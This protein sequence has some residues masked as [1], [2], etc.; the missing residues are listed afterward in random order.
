M[1]RLVNDIVT[2]LYL[3]SDWR[4]ISS[5]VR[6][7]GGMDITRGR[8]S[9]DGDSPPQT[10]TFT[11][12]NTSGD[13]TERDPMGTWYG[14]LGRN[15]PLEVSLR[16]A[17]DTC[18]S[19]VVDGW[20]TMD[21]DAA[22]AWTSYTWITADG[23][24]SDY[25]KSSGK[26]THTIS[27]ANTGKNCYLDGFSHRDLDVTT[28][29]TTNASSNIAGG[30][31]AVD[32][33][34]RMQGYFSDY[35]YVRM[36][37][38]TDESIGVDIGVPSVGS[39]VSGGSIAVPGLTWTSGLV[40][41]FRA[42]I[43][44]Q[45]IRVKIWN[46]ASAEP[47]DWSLTLIDEALLADTD[48]LRVSAG[49]FAIRSLTGAGNTN[50]PVVVSFDDI[51]IRVPMYFGEVSEWPQTRDVSGTDKTVEIEASGVLRR[52][53]QGRNPI[54]APRRAIPND[55]ECTYY[56]PLEEGPLA[57]VAK[58]LVG[59]ANLLSLS[60][61]TGSASVF[62]E[63]TLA[64]WLL[65][66]PIVKDEVLG[67]EAYTLN[68]PLF[69]AANGWRVEY[70]R[71][72]IEV[73]DA[74]DSFYVSDNADGLWLVTIDHSTGDISVLS[75]YS[76]VTTTHAPLTSGE[77][78]WIKLVVQGSG[79]VTWSLF[80]NDLLLLTSS[81]AGSAQAV[82]QIVF[83]GGARGLAIGH[84]AIYHGN[85]ASGSLI[86]PMLGNTGE[87]TLDR[88]VRLCDENEVAATFIGTS[89]DSAMMGPQGVKTTVELLRECAATD[90]GILYEDRT[91]GGLVIR[92]LA[93]M[94]SLSSWATLSLS[95]G[96]L[97]PPW[98]PTSDDR[99][100]R[101][102]VTVVRESG[103]S[104]TYEI[105]SGRMSTLPPEQGGAGTVDDSVTLSLSSEEQILDQAAWRAHLG[106]V[107][108]ERYPAVVVELHRDEIRVNNPTLYAKLLS[109]DV[110]DQITL[111]DLDAT[112]IY[113]NPDQIVIGYERLLTRFT[114]TLKLNCA[115]ASPYKVLVLDGDRRLDSRSSTL[116][117]DLD[118]TETGVDVAT[119]DVFDLWATT[120]ANP[121]EFPFDIIVGGE[122]MTVTAITGST[123]P[124]TF[125]VTRSVNGVVK[126]HSAGAEVH[127]FEP[128]RFGL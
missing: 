95:G 87:R 63:G 39:I 101:N 72:A 124:Q 51:D 29:I 35:Y 82:R 23:A 116:D 2:K 92:T 41:K 122:R 103:G 75:P 89:T 94:Y 113:D 59:N 128:F 31:I 16:I 98:K 90:G 115:P 117:E 27:V 91:S 25:A 46:A 22:G 32:Y 18:S 71:Q 45:T 49:G 125:T 58:P 85:T 13:Y 106:T 86:Y 118:T 8:R 80:M 37:L 96:E 7:A 52:L 43:E 55:S 9:E 24:P 47:Y 11:L 93:S 42:Q 107:D 81:A 19:T 26:A 99:Y 84:I 66:G 40:L 62:G 60:L 50:V 1:T 21:T 61:G 30:A 4:D 77:G 5:D 14:H 119:S 104:S 34:M 54:S 38:N 10:C 121:G 44:G 53:S 112:G 114:H 88:F 33:L 17:K 65:N 28:T 100:L 57:T 70:F 83:T 67:V 73:D 97:S 127:V 68:Q 109:L 15:T 102:K 105:T 69:T 123:S 108:E 6:A 74:G 12:D 120:A 126:P 48:T 111:S 36:L 3:A 64:P 56:W 110:G 79:T 78:A 20:G 76:T